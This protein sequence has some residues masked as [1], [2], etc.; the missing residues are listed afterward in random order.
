MSNEV[1]DL[2]V[3]HI[4]QKIK[5]EI[6]ERQIGR[7]KMK[8]SEIEKFKNKSFYHVTDFYAFEGKEFI[9]YLYMGVLKREADQDGLESHLKNM[10]NNAVTKEEILK[11]ICNSEEGQIKK[12]KILGLNNSCNNRDINK[13]LTGI[14]FLKLKGSNE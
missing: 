2:S 4:M 7:S 14:K 10:S 8:S 1:K 9:E 3:E 12:T 6:Y 13:I 11:F 5:S